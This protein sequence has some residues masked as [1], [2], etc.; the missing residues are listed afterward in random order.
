MGIGIRVVDKKETKSNRYAP[1]GFTRNPFPR[2]PSVNINSSDDRE[3]GSI[4]IPDLRLTEIDSFKKIV[5]PQ[6]NGQETKNI[7]FLMDY[8]TRQGRGIGKTSFLNY[9]H[10]QINKDLG[11]D[12]SQGGEVLFAV[13]ASPVPGDVYKKFWN[14][15][16]LI[17]KSII[18]QNL[19]SIAI[20]RLRVLSKE[21]PSDIVEKVSDKDILE[22]IGSDR[23]L[24]ENGFRNIHELNYTVR[25]NLESKGVDSKLSER[26]ARFGTVA[27]DF[28]KYYIEPMS[29][30]EWKKRANEMLFNDFV[31]VF[32]QAGFTKGIILFDELEKIVQPQNSQDRRSFCEELRYWCIDGDNNNAINSFFNVL[33]VIHPYIQELLNP[34]WAASGLERFSSLGGHFDDMST[35]FFT[36]IK[37]EQAIPLAIEYM[38]NSRADTSEDISPFTKDGLEDALI[39]SLKVPGKFLSFLHQLIEKA[40]DDKWQ[41]IDKAK[42]N[43]LSLSNLS[44]D[45]QD[46]GDNSTNTIND[47]KVKL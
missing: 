3:N 23:W 36:P 11:D 18:D 32:S 47:P 20:C 22:T 35:V 31:T 34:H 15:T 12:I 30:T 16:K 21:L 44:V 41:V 6:K 10:K 45:L 33:L 43:A 42:V 14:F 38:K 39:K 17:I 19:F 1:L 13:Y 28:S 26:A 46:E 9:Q 8:A 2:K 7:S 4:Y 29:D 24:M 5:V 37:E 25:R 40:I 27:A